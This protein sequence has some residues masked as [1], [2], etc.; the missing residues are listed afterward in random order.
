MGTGKELPEIVQA[1]A[2]PKARVQLFTSLG[3]EETLDWHIYLA[4]FL[5][6]DGVL[7]WIVL[8]EWRQLGGVVQGAND[9]RVFDAAKANVLQLAQV[10]DDGQAAEP[11]VTFYGDGDAVV[12]KFPNPLLARGH[13]RYR[14]IRPGQEARTILLL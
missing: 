7:F 9:H 14:F 11:L 13:D 4:I 2:N 3:S 1:N 12:I 8:V 6:Y 5:V 10:A